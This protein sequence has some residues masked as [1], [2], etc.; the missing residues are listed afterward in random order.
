MVL[1]SRSNAIVSCNIADPEYFAS[2]WQRF[3]EVLFPWSAYIFIHA[4]LQGPFRHSKPGE[5]TSEK[6]QKGRLNIFN[7]RHMLVW[8]PW[9]CWTSEFF[10]HAEYV[11]SWCRHTYEPLTMLMNLK[12]NI[13][14]LFT[15]C[16]LIPILEDFLTTCIRMCTQR[17]DTPT[18]SCVQYINPNSKAAPKKRG[19]KFPH[20]ML[21]RVSRPEVSSM[22]LRLLSPLSPLSPLSGYGFAVRMMATFM[23]LQVVTTKM[24]PRHLW[25]QQTVVRRIENIF[26]SMQCRLTKWWI[27]IFLFLSK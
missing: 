7:I 16:R 8:F 15:K 17:A 5:V 3:R 22:P 19:H 14:E 21:A 25:C 27:R 11:K 1:L 23:M 6:R 2:T 20:E 4:W 13:V 18:I 26:I 9:S 24:R 12:I 10:H